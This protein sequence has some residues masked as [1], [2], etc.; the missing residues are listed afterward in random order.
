MRIRD[1]QMMRPWRPAQGIQGRIHQ[2]RGVNHAGDGGNG[3]GGNNGHHARH[4]GRPREAALR[5][6]YAD[7]V[8]KFDRLRQDRAEMLKV[9]ALQRL[10]LYRLAEAKGL[11][12]TALRI[13]ANT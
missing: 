4:G 2:R 3:A 6:E 11:S 5:A 12:A 10:E 13:I 1:L 9:C 7:L 8:Q